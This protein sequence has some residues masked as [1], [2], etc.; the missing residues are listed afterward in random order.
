MPRYKEYLINREYSDYS[1]AEYLRTPFLI[2]DTFGDVAIEKID[3]AFYANFISFFIIEPTGAKT[4]LLTHLQ[5]LEYFVKFLES[6]DLKTPLSS[7][8]LH[9]EQKKL[10]GDLDLKD[11]LENYSGD[12]LLRKE[13]NLLKKYWEKADIYGS[14]FVATRNRL[15][16]CLLSEL[17]LT[18]SEL[19]GIRKEDFYE[20]EIK[21]R[22]SRIITLGE[23]ANKLSERIISLSEELTGLFKNYLSL[24]KGSYEYIIVGIN[25]ETDDHLTNR[26]VQR[27]IKLTVRKTNI[28][29][30]ITP[31]TFRNTKILEVLMEDKLSYKEFT[32]FFGLSLTNTSYQRFL[33]LARVRLGIDNWQSINELVLSRG[34]DYNNLS[35]SCRKGIIN[36]MKWRGQWYIKPGQL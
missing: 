5:H 1:V 2:T 7:I 13:I 8:D 32:Q 24:R 27:I 4:R 35:S 34:Y 23:P 15:I 10:R 18:I 29:K 17:G 28:K 12:Y 31:Q 14:D 26:E 36:C 20:K 25:N 21:I 33:R 6:I 11:R 30:D 16:F 22:S 3:R 19:T 9:V